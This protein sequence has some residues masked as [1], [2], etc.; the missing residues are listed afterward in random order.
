M[1][2][3]P[4]RQRRVVYAISASREEKGVSQRE[5]SRKLKRHPTYIQRIEAMQRNLNVAEFLEIAEALDV[6]LKDF[7]DR[8]RR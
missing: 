3:L 2:S 5:L 1:A 4:A 8:V 6:D 7:I